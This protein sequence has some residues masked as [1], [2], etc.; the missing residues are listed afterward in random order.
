MIKR[1][2]SLERLFL[3]LNSYACSTQQLKVIVLV[4]EEN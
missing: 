2:A 4:N 3:F 1:A